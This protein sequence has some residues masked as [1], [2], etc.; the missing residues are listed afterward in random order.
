MM[1]CEIL[2]KYEAWK[3]KQTAYPWRNEKATARKATL[4]VC[5]TSIR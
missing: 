1:M 3:Y 2:Y 5:S 4:F